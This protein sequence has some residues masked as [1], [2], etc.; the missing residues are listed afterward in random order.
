MELEPQIKFRNLNPSP[1]IEEN[2]RQ[3]LAKLE[4]F[5]KHIIGCRVTVEAPHKHQHKGQIYQVKI[6]LTVP[7]GE[8]LANRASDKDHTHEDVYVAIRD[9]FHAARRQ[10]EEYSHKRRGDVKSH[11]AQPVGRVAR[12]FADD[13]YGFIETPEAREIYFHAHSVLGNAFSKIAVGDLVEFVEEMGDK[14]PQ[15]STVKT[16]GKHSAE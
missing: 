3:H 12:L 10:L 1:A 14:G 4:R 13:E 16:I 7:G 15:A 6:D 2:V 5:H 8:L 11:D 9:A